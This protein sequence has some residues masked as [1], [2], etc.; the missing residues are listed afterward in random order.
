M[1]KALRWYQIDGI[2]FL[3]KHNYR[4]FIA[5]APGTGKTAQILSAI[6]LDRQKLTPALVIAPASVTGNWG[7][8]M[9]E[10]AAWAKAFIVDDTKTEIPTDKDVIIISWSLLREREIELQTYGFKLV[11]ADEAHF[12]KNEEAQRTKAFTNVISTAPHLILMSGTPLINNEEELQT[13]KSFYNSDNVPMI[14]RLLE[15]V[16][17]DVPP[18]KRAYLHVT[19]PDHIQREY[20]RIETEFED[21]LVDKLSKEDDL[22]NMDD[23]V[24]TAVEMEALIKVGYL[25]RLVSRGKIKPAADFIAR[26]IRMGEPIVVFCEHQEVIQG[27]AHKLRKARIHHVIVDGSTPRKKR[28]E[29]V[30][31]FRDYKIPVFIASKAAKEGITLTSA[32]N[33][34][35]VERWFTSADEEQAEDRIRRLTQAYPTRIWFLHAPKTIDDHIANIVETKRNMVKRAIGAFD[36]AEDESTVALEMVRSWSKHTLCQPPKGIAFGSEKSLDPLPA[37][38]RVCYFNFAAPKWETNSAVAWC[39]MLGYHPI[40]V[41]PSDKGVRVY[42][43]EPRRFARGTFVVEKIA[44]DIHAVVGDF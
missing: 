5:D 26:A 19:L 39:K 3:Q 42:N 17:P 24:K 38:G 7:E 29:Y 34:L 21:W 31:D 10:W 1:A 27:I 20:K 37:P 43:H 30:R 9:R 11:V 18:K 28:T 16:A 15:D 32:R 8:E 36:V 22:E 33:M 41:E 14:R 25:R 40:K 35:F 2:K 4:A 12:A 23:R 13:L 6:T 44:Q